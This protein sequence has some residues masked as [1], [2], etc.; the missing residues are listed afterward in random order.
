MLITHLFEASRAS[1]LKSHAAIPPRHRTLR[2]DLRYLMDFLLLRPPTAKRNDLSSASGWLE[3][4][5]T[6]MLQV[7]FFCGGLLLAPSRRDGCGQR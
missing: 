1:D 5:M 4:D 3:A 7:L 2:S 6:A